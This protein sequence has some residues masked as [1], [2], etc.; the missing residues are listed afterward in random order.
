MSHA[1]PRL[2]IAL[3]EVWLW[4]GL[5]KLICI[6]SVQIEEVEIAL[7]AFKLNIRGLGNGEQVAVI[8]FWHTRSLCCMLRQYQRIV[9]LCH[10]EKQNQ[11]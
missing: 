5:V 3:S 11:T 9:V 6:G 10:N 1:V 4:T 2:P 7:R 8:M